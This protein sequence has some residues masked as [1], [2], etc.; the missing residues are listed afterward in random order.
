MCSHYNRLMEAILMRTNN[1]SFSIYKRKI[2]IIYPRSAAN[3][4]KNEFEKDV[5]NDPSVIEPLKF[6]EI[7]SVV[8]K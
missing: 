4:L 3:E 1:I 6:Q 8:L 2:T 5:V 7:F